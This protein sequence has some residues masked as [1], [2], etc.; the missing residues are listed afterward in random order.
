[1]FMIGDMVEP[2]I[3]GRHPS[4]TKLDRNGDLVFHTDFRQAYAAVLDHWMGTD[5]TKVLG[6]KFTPMDVINKKL[7]A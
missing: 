3:H 2:G 5:S 1:M 4:L 6:K 7:R